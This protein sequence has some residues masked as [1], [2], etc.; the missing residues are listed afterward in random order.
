MTDISIRIAATDREFEAARDLCRQWLD[1]HWK[2]YPD[3]W[4]LEGNPMQRDKFEAVVEDL[5]RLHARPEGAIL[6]AFL[7]D[8]PV[9][10][11]MYNKQQ[12]GVAEFNRMFVS[13]AG[14]GHGVGGK[15]L[16]RMFEQMVADGYEKVIFSSAK[17]L[18]H[19]R[20]MYRNAGFEDMPHPD[21]FPDA[22]R[23]YVYFMQ[24]PLVS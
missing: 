8:Q 5:E 16:E 23:D 4:P 17:F 6:V 9:G 3:D 20:T 19:A 1:W 7:D 10:C 2:N 22:W 14:R 15:M 21:G 11:V 18:T 13:E 24:R 12:A